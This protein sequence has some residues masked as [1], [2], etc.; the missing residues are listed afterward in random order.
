MSRST[1]RGERSSSY[2]TAPTKNSVRSLSP[3]APR[4]KALPSARPAHRAHPLI[5]DDDSVHGRVR[6]A[7]RLRPRNAEDLASDADYADCIELQP[8]LKRLRLRKNNW[9]S[10]SFKFDDVFTESAS[11]KRVYEV[12][13]RPV[14]E[15]VLNGYNGTVMAYGQTGTGKTYTVGR[16]GKEDPSERGIMVR[17]LEDILA[18]TSELDSASVSYLQLYMESIQDLLV[19]EK[20]NIPI[21]EDPRTGEVSLPGVEKVKIR[22]LDHFLEVIQIGEANRHT[23]FTKLNTESSRSHAILMVYIQKAAKLKDEDA[24][25][26]FESSTSEPRINGRDVPLVT[27][28]K[29]L[30]VDLAGSERIG[31]SGS[32]GHSLEEA[33]SINLS[34]TSLGK[35]INALAENSPH[36]PTRDSKLTRLLRDSFGGS[37]RTSLVVTIGPSSRHHSETSSTIMFGQ[38]AMKV[39]N[40]I[41]LKEEFDYE[42]H[43]RNLEHRLDH[44]IT[45][46]ERRDSYVKEMELK[47]KR[48]QDSLE[49]AGKRLSAC[50][51]SVSNERHDYEMQIRNLMAELNLEKERKNNVE[52]E[53]SDLR[54]RLDDSV[55]ITR[56]HSIE[57]ATLSKSHKDSLLKLEKNFKSKH[58]EKKFLDEEFDAIQRKMIEKDEKSMQLELEVSTYQKVLADTTQMY[59]QKISE[60][61]EQLDEERKISQGAKSE[62]EQLKNKINDQKK[63]DQFEEQGELIELRKQVK[64]LYGHHEY[65]TSEL[66]SLQRENEELSNGKLKLI[67]ELNTL[68]QKLKDEEIERKKVEVEFLKIKRVSDTNID[69]LEKTQIPEKLDRV[70]LGED[71]SLSFLMSNQVK[72]SMSGQRTTISK[73]FEEVGL[74]NVLALLKSEE[75]DVQIH[76][77]KV[78]A[79]L[80]AEDFNQEKIVEE[81]GLDAL[82]M[83]LESS[84]NETILRVASGAIANLAM[85]ETNQ[86]LIISKGG[87]QLLSAIAYRATDPQTFRMVAGAI[88]NLC[89]NERLHTMLK[90]ANAI[91]ALLE[92]A[93]SGQ[94]DVLSQVARGIANFAKCESRGIAQGHRKGQ[95]LLIED[96]ALPWIVSHTTSSQLS[97]RRH[98]ELALCHLAQHEANTRDLISSGGLKELIRLSHESTRDDIRNLAKRILTIS[99]AFRSEIQRSC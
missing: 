95:S 67:E 41:K 9:S 46:I 15:S 23:T 5:E 2:A 54:C 55:H 57:L 98:M 76:A 14:V 64:E 50:A 91:Q 80:A 40:M 86:G 71:K 48:C 90:E 47:L 1:L 92:M 13:A 96:G 16:L 68:R 11:Q 38:R 74:P 81:G 77:V 61:I 78:V 53:V 51:G 43:S 45:E 65:A 88:A 89:G 99:P 83:L 21:V 69:L 52:E 12:V 42:S 30:I 22:D 93:R 36:V 34:L 44:L 94:S 59:E 39:E 27:K 73:I 19:P 20:N 18:S 4:S 7:V 87:A 70:A 62:L 32:E 79:N 35:C 60:L 82:L 85:T 28:S 66:Q 8:E 10:E 49:D 33:K 63:L 97:V 56:Q 72:G 31:K 26:P 58:A 24:Y 17:S 6:V 25:A 75:L 3:A 84:E 37:A 29:L